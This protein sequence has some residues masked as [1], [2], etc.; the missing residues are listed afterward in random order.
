MRKSLGV[1][2]AVASLLSLTA[3]GAAPAGAAAGTTCA[4]TGGLVTWTPPLPVKAPGIKDHI[5]AAGTFGKCTGA[6]A[7]AHTTLVTPVGKTPSSCASTLKY[8]T[9][10]ETTGTL[11]V[12]WNKGAKSVI[13]VS[14]FKV[15]G[16]PTQAL[17]TG[18]VKSGQFA[19]AKSSGKVSYTPK[20]GN[21]ATTPLKSATYKQV[22]SLTIK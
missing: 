8:S 18:T 6:V 7:S 4:T 19:G 10:A 14:I 11:T 21:C 20:V 9:G 3:L 15:K 12:T 13:A 22:G 5:S 16:Q 1:L 17:V 2:V